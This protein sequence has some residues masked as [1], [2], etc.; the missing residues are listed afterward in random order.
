[1]ADQAIEVG[2]PP[3]AVLRVVNS[4]LRRVLPTPLGA[5]IGEFMLVGFTGRK[6]GKRYSTPVSAHRLDGDLYVVLEAPWKVNFRDGAD[7]TV[8]YRGKTS[9]MRGVLIAER[10]TVADVVQRL[11]SSYGAKKAQRMMGLKFPGG[12][13]PTSEE[14]GEAVDRLG[15]AA[16]KL[17]AKA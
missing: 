10:S 12:R 16:I 11:A 8:S 4:V 7:A 3:D 2:H 14:W 5:P 6:T 17:T 15:I 13:V 1:M 9:T